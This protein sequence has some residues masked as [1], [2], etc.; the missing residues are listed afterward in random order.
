MREFGIR[1]ALGAT[2]SE[3]TRLAASQGMSPAVA[4]SAVGL[5]VAFVA[6]GAMSKLVFGVAPRDAV[7]IISATAVLLV[8][9]VIASYVPARQAGAVDP[10][11]TLRAE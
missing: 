10:G 7:S 6:S 1:V 3:V 9:T 5:A 8:V 4:G 11:I 2:V